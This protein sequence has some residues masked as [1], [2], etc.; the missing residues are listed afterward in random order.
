MQLIREVY[1]CPGKQDLSH[2]DDTPE[3]SLKPDAIKGCLQKAAA[4]LLTLPRVEKFNFIFPGRSARAF[5]IT[6]V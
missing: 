2:L 1:L 6:P 4:N 3:N 5:P